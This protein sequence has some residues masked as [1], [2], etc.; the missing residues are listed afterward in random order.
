MRLR[1][2]VAADE[3]MDMDAGFDDEYD[4]FNDTLDDI[5][6]DIEDMK[7]SVDEVEEDDVSIEADNNIA[8]HYIAEC[9]ACKGIFISAVVESE[10][11]IDYVSGQCPLCG[12]ESDQ[13]LKW[14][15]HEVEG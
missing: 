12:K 14:V 5:A 8:G 6:D 15:I 9:D 3:D 4:S 1:R 2:I 11:Q 13:Y 10:Q 7:D